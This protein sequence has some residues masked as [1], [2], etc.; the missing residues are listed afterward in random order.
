[1]QLLGYDAA[2]IGNHEYDYGTDHLAAYLKA[3]GYPDA[4][5][6]TVVLASN[7]I[8]PSGHPLADKDLFRKTHLMV[9]ENGLKIGLFS[10][11]GRSAAGVIFLILKIPKTLLFLQPLNSCGN[12]ILSS[13]L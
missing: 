3:A 4:H 13:L 6:Q 2:V 1:M 5:D 12:C 10:L 7:A 11:I 9:L 8:V